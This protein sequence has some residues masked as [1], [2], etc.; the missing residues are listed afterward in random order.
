MTAILQALGARPPVT[1][2]PPPPPPTLPYADLAAALLCFDAGTT[3]HHENME[4]LCAD[5]LQRLAAALPPAQPP[6]QPVPPP[7]ELPSLQ[8]APLGGGGGSGRGFRPFREVVQGQH[9]PVSSPS[10][11]AALN[12]T[13]QPVD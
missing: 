9:P 12:L 6:A 4:G 2:P 3:D 1:T 8:T 11:A 13:A 10:F 5:V 7:T